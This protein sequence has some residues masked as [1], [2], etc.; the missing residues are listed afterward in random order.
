M[1]A[2]PNPN[3]KWT[4]EPVIVNKAPESPIA[5]GWKTRILKTDKGKKLP[6][7]ANALTALRYAPEWDQVL[8]FNESSLNVTAMQTP[9]WDESR[10]VPFDWTDPDDVKTAAWMQHQGIHVNSNIAGQ[11]VQVVAKEHSFHPIRDYLNSLVWDKKKRIDTWL[12]VCLGVKTK[13][14][15]E[16]SA[17]KEYS[18]YIAAVGSKFLKGAVARVRKPGCKHDS[19]LI[20]E[21]EQGLLKSTA[22]RTL[23]EPF[24]TD[25]IADLGS[26]DAALS[27]RGVWCIELAELDSM[28]RPEISRVKAFISRQTDRFRPPYGRRL[29]EVPRESVFAGTCNQ[30][31]Y[32]RDETGGRRF[33]PIRCGKINIPLLKRVKDQLWAEAV[34][35]FEA[36]ET[37]WFDNKEIVA[38]AKQEQQARY[39][40]DPWSEVIEPWLG[41]NNDVSISDVLKDCLGKS[42]EFW[43][44][45]DKNRVGRILCAAGWKRY[46]GSDLQYRYRPINQPAKTEAK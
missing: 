13:I 5:D 4:P 19:C 30:S 2:V 8:G 35:R 40:G 21:G 3:P 11:A 25:D 24:F 33:W 15:K 28:S 16:D 10:E 9:P 18:D 22:L 27:T 14:Y 45:Q 7:V 41:K 29:I 37:W 32:L 39:E 20:L 34:V 44:Q 46:R 1:S 17:N 6:I 23:F 38:T 26:K 36:G 12:K 42:K 31:T 43:S